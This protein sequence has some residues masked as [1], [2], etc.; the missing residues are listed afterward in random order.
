MPDIRAVFIFLYFLFEDTGDKFRYFM[1]YMQ[2][3]SVL[4]SRSFSHH[5]VYDERD[6]SVARHV[7]GGSEAVHC[8]V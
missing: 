1:L 5:F 4:F 7:A 3:K 6:G 2:T 8:D